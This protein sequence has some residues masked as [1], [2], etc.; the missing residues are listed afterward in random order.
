MTLRR[1]L[2]ALALL[3]GLMAGTLST[4]LAG[5]APSQG[6]VLS[7]QQDDDATPEAD[8]DTPSNR[9]SGETV[10]DVPVEV[11]DESGNPSLEITLSNFSDDW[12]DYEDYSAPDRGFHYIYFELTVENIGKRS[13]DVASYDFFVRGADGFLYGKTYLSVLEDS[14]T[15]ELEEFDPQDGI[16][17]GDTYTGYLVV[18]VPNDTELVDIF[19]APSGRLI[20]L[21]TLGGDALED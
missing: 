13:A 20:T 9:T 3:F 19:Y 6:A 21:A 17:A 12:E 16:E 18:M 8:D 4:A 15:A 1:S 2:F 14:P 7:A 11:V 10:E 5:G